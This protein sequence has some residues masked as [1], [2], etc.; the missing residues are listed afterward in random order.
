MK[1]K[2]SAQEH[3]TGERE[4]R[5]GLEKEPLDLESSALTIRPKHLP[6]FRFLCIG[7]DPERP[8][9]TVNP[10]KLIKEP[11][12]LNLSSGMSLLKMLF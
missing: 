9:E 7:R 3:N 4:P 12:T 11:V 8:L 1:V 10:E 6:L 5:P 2:C